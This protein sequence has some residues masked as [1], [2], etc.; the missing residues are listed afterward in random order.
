MSELLTDTIAQ[1]VLAQDTRETPLA[2]VRFNLP[3]GQVLRYVNNNEPIEGS[4]GTYAVAP[5]EV[6][7]PADTDDGDN[8]VTMRVD[9]IDHEVS[10]TIRAQEGIPTAEIE[11]VMAAAP[12]TPFVGPYQLQVQQ[13]TTDEL[14]IELDM[15]AEEDFLNQ[16]IPAQSVTP[17]NSPGYWGAA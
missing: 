14:S 9:N 3:D 13:A 17:S 1:A 6:S 7:L 8:G 5:F 15:G 4:D 16:S 2:R 11:V 12:A 10:R